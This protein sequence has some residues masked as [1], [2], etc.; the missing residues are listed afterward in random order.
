MPVPSGQD[1]LR[2]QRIRIRG[3]QS[4][5]PF[6]RPPPGSRNFAISRATRSLARSGAGDLRDEAKNEKENLNSDAVL[7][8]TLRNKHTH[9]HATLRAISLAGYDGS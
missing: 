1:N 8:A 7:D 5:A 9:S 6:W 4:L 2:P 3:R